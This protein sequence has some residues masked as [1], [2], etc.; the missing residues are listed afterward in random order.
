MPDQLPGTPW[1]IRHV[2]L[3][4]PEK[5]RSRKPDEEKRAKNFPAKNFPAKKY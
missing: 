1:V 5:K 4:Q 3:Q 2:G